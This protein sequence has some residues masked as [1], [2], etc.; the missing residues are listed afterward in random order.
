MAGT[1]WTHE[2]KCNSIKWH[3]YL[4]CP[5]HSIYYCKIL[6]TRDCLRHFAHK[7]CLHNMSYGYNFWKKNNGNSKLFAQ[8]PKYSTCYHVSAWRRCVCP[9]HRLS[10]YNLPMAESHAWS[11]LLQSQSQPINEKCRNLQ[12]IKE[13]R[14]A[15]LVSWRTNWSL[16]VMEK[17]TFDVS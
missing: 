17:Y 9:S 11:P 5:F 10:C 16:C 12:P 3:S 8:T 15:K 14:Q 2:L 6:N 1:K 13:K 4:F 7:M